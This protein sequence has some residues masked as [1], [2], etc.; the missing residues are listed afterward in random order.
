[1]TDKSSNNNN[2]EEVV[3]FSIGEQNNINLVNDNEDDGKLELYQHHRFSTRRK[4]KGRLSIRERYSKKYGNSDPM[5]DDD[6]DE[7]DYIDSSF[8]PS[9]SDQYISPS[10]PPAI[11][12]NNNNNSQDEDDQNNSTTSGS[13]IENNNSNINN[14]NNEDEE[15]EEDDNDIVVFSYQNP[16]PMRKPPHSLNSS[17]NSNYSPSGGGEKQNSGNNSNSNSKIYS[18]SSKSRRNTTNYEVQNQSLDELQLLIQSLI[19][20]NKSSPETIQESEFIQYQQIYEQQ[21]LE[22]EKQRVKEFQ[23]LQLQQQQLQQQQ[24]SNSETDSDILDNIDSVIYSTISNSSSSPSSSLLPTPTITT[25]TTTTTTTTSPILNSNNNN[26]NIVKL[27]NEINVSNNNNIDLFTSSDTNST[28]IIQNLN[29]E[30]DGLKL[31]RASSLHSDYSIGSGSFSE[32]NGVNPNSRP[33]IDIGLEYKYRLQMEQNPKDYK[34][35]IKWGNLIFKK[36]KEQLG[37][38]DV[39]VCLL[40]WNEDLVPIPTQSTQQPQ[41]T[42]FTESLQSFLLKEP[43]FDACSKYQAALQLSGGN[44]FNIP[45]SSMLTFNITQKPTNNTTNNNSSSSSSKQQQTRTTPSSTISQPK[46]S[47]SSLQNGSLSRML[48]SVSLPPAP[49][50]PPGEDPNSPWSDPLLWMKWGDCLFLLC[51]YLELPMYKATCEKYHKCILLLQKQNNNKKLL[52]IVLRKWGIALSRY[53][54]R[55]KCQF[56]MSEWSNEE[57]IQVEELWKIL[58]SQSIQ[59]LTHSLNLLPSPLTAYHLATAYFRHVV[60]LNQ[61]GGP[62]G[63][64]YGLDAKQEEE[65]LEI[66]L[67]TPLQKARAIE[68]WGRALDIQLAVKLTEEESSEKEEDDLHAVDEYLTNFSKI[69]LSNIIPSLEGIISLCLNSRQAIQYKAINSLSVLCKSPELSTL[70]IYQDLLEHLEKVESFV[71]QRDDAES[72]L[73]QQKTLKS[74]PPKLQA[75]VRMSGLGED[76]I[77]KNFEIAWNSIYFLTKD[78]IPNQPVPPN[79]YRSNKK[80]KQKKPIGSPSS[81]PEEA[82]QKTPLIPSLHRTSSLI[83]TPFT[84]NTP[85][86]KFNSLNKSFTLKHSNSS[87]KLNT[88]SQ[89]SPNKDKENSTLN[90]SGGLS[91]STTLSVGGEGSNWTLTLPSKKPT[92]RAT[93]SLLDNSQEE[94]IK[95]P[96]K[97]LSRYFP[98]NIKRLTVRPPPLARCDESIFSTGNP[99]TL[100]KD[101]IKLGTGAFGNVFYA[102]QKFDNKPVAIKVLMERTK[103]GSPIIPELYIHSSCTHP[104]I[105][106]YHESYLCK[107]HLWIIMEYCDGGTVRDLLQEDWKNH[108]NLSTPNSLEEPLIAYICKQFLG[109]G[110][111][112]MCGTMG[113]IAPEIIRR[114]PYDTQVD[115]YSLGCLLVEMAEGIV[116]YGK[117]SSLKALFYTAIIEYKLVNPSRFTHEFVDFIELCLI[118]DPFQRPT[119]EMLIQHSFL[120]GWERGKQILIDR[121]KNQDLRKNNLLKNFV[122]F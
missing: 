7:S 112:R 85:E 57:N 20:Q 78:T 84:A 101:K 97:P 47:I 24:K 90:N 63:A 38:R 15:D 118:S 21:Q 76:E 111:T 89:I 64:I 35:L 116:P 91:A 106:T 121:F 70:P 113:R 4:N 75:Y 74:M 39:D 72:L 13:D 53:S 122:P 61:F 79:Y 11:N 56:L 9:Y 81:E 14:N 119:P 104:S 33:L 102:I 46:L 120:S 87:L 65:E 110:R 34:T 59:S 82:E 105:V 100:F 115:V 48:R 99:L 22:K 58:H 10:S 49:P 83:I 86:P 40:D 26:N 31:S 12:N 51:T 92:R 62:R 1:M 88:S 30:E 5:D 16:S 93:V 67:L 18:S 27:H 54:R 96:Q 55:M 107:G 71:T 43:L 41:N 95:K 28:S 52:A 98:S 23:Q 68:N 109:R 73:S 80:N 8:L 29:N 45:F 17:N 32:S 37:G 103:K 117:D 25:T 42:P 6:F 114:E 36:I 108:Q 77:M 3:I 50:P 66:T 69:I 94:E 60:T 19:D 2:N 44:N